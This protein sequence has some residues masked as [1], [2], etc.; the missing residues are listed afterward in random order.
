ML[1]RGARRAALYDLRNL[2]HARIQRIPLA[3]AD[4]IEAHEDASNAEERRWLA[5]LRQAG[6]VEDTIPPYWEPFR[7][8]WTHPFR[9]ELHTVTIDVD[10]ATFDAAC[11]WLERSHAARGLHYVFHVAGPT[12]PALAGRIALLIER[13]SAR[14]F[15]LFPVEP[16][17]A[18]SLICDR[19]GVAIARRDLSARGSPAFLQTLEPSFYRLQRNRIGSETGGQIHLGADLLVRPHRDERHYTLGNARTEAFDDIVRG[20]RL[21]ASNAAGK[22]R[23]A[24]CRDCELRYVCMRDFTRRTDPDD[25]CSAPA[26]CPYDPYSDAKQ[27]HLF[28]ATESAV[29]A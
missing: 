21:A 8:D 2:S 5:F 6:F 12:L 26:D 20:E 25:L 4:R 28:Q 7:A 18:D 15:E 11:D 29:P 19:T 16:A 14:S 24:V 17:I 3:L 27:S 13:V 23:R 1:V 9:P 22:D 10:T